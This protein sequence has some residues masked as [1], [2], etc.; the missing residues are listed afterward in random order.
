VLA[1]QQGLVPLPEYRWLRPP[2]ES[3]THLYRVGHRLG[4]PSVC[5]RSLLN[6][7]P[8]RAE[9]P[10]AGLRCPVCARYARKEDLL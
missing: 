5:H 2:D 7:L 6:V 10:A 1:P 8:D 9:P 4:I 3:R